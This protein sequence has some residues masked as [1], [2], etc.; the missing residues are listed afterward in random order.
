MFKVSAEGLFCRCLIGK[1][2]KDI[3]WHCHSSTYG[4]HNSG[5]RTRNKVLQ[6][7]FWWPALFKDC[8]SYVH[9]F[10]ECQKTCNI[11]KRD[12]MPLKCIIEVEPFDC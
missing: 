7:C 10:L 6:S 4:G 11:S 5:E 12:D 2:L 9:E 8:K 3:M 1:E